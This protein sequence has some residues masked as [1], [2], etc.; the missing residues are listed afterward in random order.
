M[1]GLLCTSYAVMPDADPKLN[2]PPVSVAT[3]DALPPIFE[4][5]T[6]DALS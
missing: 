3:S 1:I 6:E 4:G 5:V 2:V